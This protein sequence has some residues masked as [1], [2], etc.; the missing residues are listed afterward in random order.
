MQK[1][2]NGHAGVSAKSI[3]REAGDQLV[4]DRSQRDCCT[5][6]LSNR[7]CWHMA[8]ANFSTAAQSHLLLVPRKF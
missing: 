7:K 4:P 8:Q 2:S 6:G 3:R 1:A 5:T